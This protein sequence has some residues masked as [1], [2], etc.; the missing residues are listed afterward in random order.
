MEENFPH[1][2][3]EG[4]DFRMIQVHYIYCALYF[5][6]CYISSPSDHQA[7][8]PGGCGSLLTRPSQIYPG[9]LCA[10]WSFSSLE[11]QF[12]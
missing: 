4:D 1:T 12:K 9:F 7:L 5:Y 2:E 10:C 8:D 11:F 3:V 6:Y